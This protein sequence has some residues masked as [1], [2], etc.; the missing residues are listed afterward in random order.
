MAIS[1]ADPLFA[2]TPPL[3]ENDTHSTRSLARNSAIVQFS[4]NDDAQGIVN[5]E[6]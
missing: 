6:N 3:A 4:T 1:P 2:L 5:A